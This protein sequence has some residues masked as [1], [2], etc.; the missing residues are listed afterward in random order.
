MA[1]GMLQEERIG[2]HVHIRQSDGLLNLPIVMNR[3]I[4]P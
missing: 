3:N 2:R 4:A 1:K